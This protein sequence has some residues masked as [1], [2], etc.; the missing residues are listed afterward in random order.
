[1]SVAEDD[2]MEDGWRP[3]ASTRGKR[4]GET[5]RRWEVNRSL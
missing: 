2:G 4:G 1:M 5:G 3:K